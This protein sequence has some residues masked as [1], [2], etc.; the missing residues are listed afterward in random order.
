MGKIAKNKSLDRRK[1]NKLKGQR[2]RQKTG[3]QTNYRRRGYS[4][5]TVEIV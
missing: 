5:T 1:T 4:D 2:P 3:S